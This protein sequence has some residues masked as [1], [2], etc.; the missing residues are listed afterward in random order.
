M[1]YNIGNLWKLKKT[2]KKFYEML[3]NNGNCNFND[4]IIVK[5]RFGK[6]VF[7]DDFLNWNEKPIIKANFSCNFLIWDG[8][9][10]RKAKFSIYPVENCPYPILSQLYMKYPNY[11]ILSQ[12][13][14]II[15]Y[16]P[17][18]SHEKFI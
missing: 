13:S 9:P 4:G 3:K 16:Y 7:R 8:K 15:P 18:L 1:M 14:H 17:N 12:L 5:N 10:I 11:P 2:F 6:A